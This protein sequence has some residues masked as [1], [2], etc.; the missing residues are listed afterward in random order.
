MDYDIY[1]DITSN[2]TNVTDRW[3]ESLGR[4]KDVQL[5]FSIDGYDKTNGIET[6]WNDRCFFCY[7]KSIIL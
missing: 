2:L 7:I 4:F 6:E 5:Q 1:L 3:L